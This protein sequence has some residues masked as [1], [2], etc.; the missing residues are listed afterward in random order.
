MAHL[1]PTKT[2]KKLDMEI[3]KLSVNAG[4]LPEKTK[5]YMAADVKHF[6]GS[7]ETPKGAFYHAG[8]LASKTKV[9]AAS[10]LSKLKKFSLDHEK[11][12]I[13]GSAFVASGGTALYYNNKAKN[14]YKPK[15]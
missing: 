15:K 8:D 9:I 10:K 14:L 13:L 5:V 7:K 3:K 2:K 4:S 11:A 12:I 1:D 6:E